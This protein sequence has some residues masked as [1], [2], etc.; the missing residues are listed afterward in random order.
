MK[1]I[2]ITGCSSGFG[3]DASKYLASKGH[4]VYASMRNTTGK[5]KEAAAA[6]NEYASE[7][8]YK[9]EVLDIDVTSDESVNSATSGCER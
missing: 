9:I 2:L 1:N 7:N 3:Y 8:N 6:L 4:T 5:N